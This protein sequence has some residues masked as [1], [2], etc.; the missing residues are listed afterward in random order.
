MHRFTRLAIV[1]F[2]LFFAASSHANAK[3]TADPGQF[4]QSLGD[5]AVVILADK[6]LSAEQRDE[7]FRNMLRDSFDLQTIG[8][9]VIGRNSWMGATPDQQK[10]YMK[11]FEGLVIKTY[12]DRFALYTGEGFKVKTT[13]P[14]G[15]KDF[16]VNSE[17]SHP[18]GSAPTAVDWRVRVKDAKMGVIDVVVEGVSMSVTQKQEYS[19]IIQRDGG[20]IE[21]LLNEMRARLNQKPTNNG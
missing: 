9:F 1:V 8:R 5:R 17:I 15:D 4:V 16:I 11:L 20:N 10:E 3:E 19:S 2:A 12:S 18:D 7:K 14:E 6:N 13:R 21:G